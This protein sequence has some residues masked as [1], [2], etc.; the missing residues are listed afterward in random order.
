MTLYNES[1]PAPKWLAAL[2]LGG[3]A[4]VGFMI[5]LEATRGSLEGGERA[6]FYVFMTLALIV[7]GFVAFNFLVLS[8]TVT[9]EAV[10]FAYG[11]FKSRLAW[12]QVTGFSVQRYDWK[13][14]GGWGLR[15]GLHGRRAWSVPG[16]PEGLTFQASIDGKKREYFV[17]SRRTAE[18]A[19]AV[20]QSSRIPAT[21]S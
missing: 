5:G 10:E 9:S 11:V 8:I 18:F 3:M 14:Y 15:F 4:F 2:I 7:Q 21:G 1:V 6:L 19:S 17:S 20:S 13:R 12:P 16:V